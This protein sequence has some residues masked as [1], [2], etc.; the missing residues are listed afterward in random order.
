MNTTCAKNVLTR[1]PGDTEH[2]VLPLTPTPEFP[3]QDKPR[4]RPGVPCRTHKSGRD[5]ATLKLHLIINDLRN[6]PWPHPASSTLSSRQ[7]HVIVPPHPRQRSTSA[8]Q[9]ASPPHRPLINPATIRTLSLNA[10]GCPGTVMK[11]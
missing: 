6:P 11:R 7:L 3:P 2:D 8:H 5:A 4:H 1:T 9:P 10:V